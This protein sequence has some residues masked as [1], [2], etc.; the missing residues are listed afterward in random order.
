MAKQINQI[1]NG[2]VKGN[3]PY[4]NFET[5]TIRFAP[6]EYKKLMDALD[7]NSKEEILDIIFKIYLRRHFL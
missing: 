6:G 7:G 4:K 3:N 2:E 1:F 5:R